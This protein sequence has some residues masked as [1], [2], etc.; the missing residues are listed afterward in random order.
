MKN[1]PLILY[2]LLFFLIDIFV[3]YFI[4]DWIFG[5]NLVGEWFWAITLGLF[6]A[7]IGALFIINRRMWMYKSAMK[8]DPDKS[9]ASKVVL[10]SGSAFLSF[11]QI[12]LISVVAMGG[13]GLIGYLLGLL[14]SPF[15]NN[16]FI[17][18][19]ILSVLYWIA[20]ILVLFRMRILYKVIDK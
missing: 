8:K 20:V 10:I 9:K 1:K 19:G 5:Y 6:G 3:P 2:T 4:A 11:I 17:E 15:I 14:L 13:L 12:L 7:T 16:I 18:G